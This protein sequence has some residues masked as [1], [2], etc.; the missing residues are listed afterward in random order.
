MLAYISASELRVDRNCGELSFPGLMSLGSMYFP[1]T[2][3]LAVSLCLFQSVVVSL[4][5]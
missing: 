5:E 3:D 2:E 1:K 4:R